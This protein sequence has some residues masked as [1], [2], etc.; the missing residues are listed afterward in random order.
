MCVCERDRREERGTELECVFMC[1]YDERKY[2]CEC[3]SVCVLERERERGR[4]KYSVLSLLSVSV[5]DQ[6]KAFVFSYAHTFLCLNIEI[7]CW[8]MLFRRK[9]S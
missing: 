4:V 3:V 6:D 8:A 1:M 7:I 2:V 5:S 9:C